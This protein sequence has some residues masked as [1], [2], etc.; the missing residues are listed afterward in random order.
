[1][2]VINISKKY[3]EGFEPSLGEFLKDLR[4]KKSLKEVSE[5]TEISTSTLSN[6]ENFD[7]NIKDSGAKIG[8]I[9]S[10]LKYYGASMTDL[11]FLEN[12]HGNKGMAFHQNE[13][14]TKNKHYETV[15]NVESTGN[16]AQMLE[17][18]MDEYRVVEFVNTD[19]PFVPMHK[20]DEDAIFQF[21]LHIR[22]ILPKY[23]QNPQEYVYYFAEIISIY[24]AYLG[25][26]MD[27]D[28]GGVY[29]CLRDIER[30]EVRENIAYLRKSLNE[31]YGNINKGALIYTSS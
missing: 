26:R 5:D 19:Y 2:E 29:R 10:L 18:A 23:R 4:G 3:H 17:N 11:F 28:D 27:A 25:C 8:N 13:P 15:G 20:K 1:M 9:L 12:E 16:L 14:V 6:Y 21:I 24:H 31:V 22:E 30:D 7:G